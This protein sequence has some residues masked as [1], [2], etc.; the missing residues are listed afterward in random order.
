M[1]DGLIPTS[2]RL[3]RRKPC[4][5]PRLAMLHNVAFVCSPQTAF[6]RSRLVS[7]PATSPHFSPGSRPASRPG[8]RSARSGPKSVSG[9]TVE[10]RDA[11]VARDAGDVHDLAMMER[12]DRQEAREPRQVPDQTL[13]PDLLAEI[14]PGIAPEHRSPILDMPVHLVEEVGKALDLVDDHPARR[15][16]GLRTRGEE[17]RNLR[18]PRA[19]R[20]VL[21]GRRQTRRAASF[22]RC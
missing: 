4:P 11:A 19:F 2:N 20:R 16:R 14:E 9:N 8:V 22:G 10:A 17:K 1:S 21:H 15:R 12:G 7:C 18:G 6:R 3:R 5:L 13:G